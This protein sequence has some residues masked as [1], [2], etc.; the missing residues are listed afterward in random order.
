M[1]QLPA[2]H[3]PGTALTWNN[4]LSPGTRFEARDDGRVVLAAD[5]APSSIWITAP[6][7][8]HGPREMI[9]RL[10]HV[11]PGT[12]I[13]L[14]G[15]DTGSG[16]PLIQF[17]RHRR[18]ART[19][20]VLSDSAG[21]QERDWG[22]LSNND[23]PFV[24]DVVWLR[25]ALGAGSLRW[26]VS[27]DGLHWAEA[28]Q[29]IGTLMPRCNQLGLF[30][31]GGVEGCRIE[32][33]QVYIRPLPQ[34][35]ALTLNHELTQAHELLD[36]LVVE[37][38]FLAWKESV[39]RI[40]P[41]QLDSAT[42]ER[43]CAVASL[44]LG[45]APELGGD[46]LDQLLD[47]PSLVTWTLAGRL[48]LLDEVALLSNSQF[49]AAS[50]PNLPERYFRL[51]TELWRQRD[52]LPMSSIRAALM[53]SPLETRYEVDWDRDGVIRQQLL[54]LIYSN[55]WEPLRRTCR[56]L[57]YFGLFRNDPLVVW[58]DQLSAAGLQTAPVISNR[59]TPSINWHPLLSEEQSRDAYNQ[60]VQLDRL[61]KSG[62]WD[63]AAEQISHT[64]TTTI[65]G[66]ALSPDDST[67]LM[68]LPA[69][70]RHALQ[71]HPDLVSRFERDHGDLARLRI[72]QAIQK[73]QLHAVWQLAEQYFGLAAS[74]SAYRWLG[75]Q[76]LARGDAD[77][78]ARYYRQAIDA[79]EHAADDALIARRRIAAALAGERVDIPIQAA[80]QIGDVTLSPDQL[81]ELSDE[82]LRRDRPNGPTHRAGSL[83][84]PHLT[85]IGVRRILQL[86]VGQDPSKEILPGMDALHVDWT[87]RQ[88]AAVRSDGRLLVNNRF[89]LAALDWQTGKTLWTSTALDEKILR[90]R[91]WPLIAMRP[92]VHGDR[93]LVR[94]L[95][96]TAPFLPVGT[97]PLASCYGNMGRTKRYP[98]RTLS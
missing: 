10:T 24:G 42:W 77:L 33:E 96:G 66:V 37:R 68:S 12:G 97:S 91:D 15:I 8:G 44:G 78:A 85:D 13:F 22:T 57:D 74:R 88:L 65:E 17:L 64:L 62:S 1:E 4:P 46:L 39:R 34:L 11:T 40:R 67:L 48:Q 25:L 87:G 70:V 83:I 3:V 50:S 61:L 9:L 21:R 73:C 86:A 53:T 16:H 26:W 2:S 82:L 28:E 41:P 45:C 36:Q 30:C 35:N 6:V 76:S 90:A 52:E 71:H 20:V 63:E 32:V 19:C 27:A 31:P 92:L 72:A 95:Y 60:L 18:T 49:S 69:A 54:A 59:R 89:Q 94:Q 80:V 14:G 29:P 58:A 55:R 51:G 38:D 75:D 5:R 84:R 7:P 81:A 93:V 79:P 43:A 47:D 56:V 98:F 23:I